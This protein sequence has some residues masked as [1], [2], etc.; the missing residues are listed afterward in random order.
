MRERI[1]QFPSETPKLPVQ[2]TTS[3]NLNPNS[4]ARNSRMHNK[5]H[6]VARRGHREGGG[7]TRHHLVHKRRHL[8]NLDH[9]QHQHPLIH[10]ERVRIKRRRDERDTNLSL[11]VHVQREGDGKIPPIGRRIV[12]GVHRNNGGSKGLELGSHIVRVIGVQAQLG[13]VRARAEIIQAVRVAPA[14]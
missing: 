13:R 2:T 7:P 5:K 14:H 8:L 6:V 12:R 11:T 9:V 1:T 4:S 3:L 10:R